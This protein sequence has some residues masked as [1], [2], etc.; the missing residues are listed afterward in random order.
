[1]TSAGPE[2]QAVSQPAQRKAVVVL[3][4]HRSGTSALTR[5]ISALGCDL[6]RTLMPPDAEVNAPGYWESV[7]VM[8]L[9]DRVLQAAHSVWHDWTAVEP[10]WWHSEAAAELQH[11]AR[12][13][14]E[15]E[16]GASRLFVLKDPR[17][18]RLFPFWHAVLSSAGVEPLVLL[19][20][21]NPLE[22]AASLQ[23]RNGFPLP[24]SHLLWQRHVLDA[25]AS[26]R[27]R[28]RLFTSYERLLHDWTGITQQVRATFDVPWPKSATE[29]EQE[30]D[31][32][33]SEQH[34]HH[35]LDPKGVL[36]DPALTEG[37]RQTYRIVS[38]W[39]EEGERAEDFAELDRLRAELD[40]AAPA[41]ASLLREG[42]ASRRREAELERQDKEKQAALVSMKEQLAQLQKQLEA[43]QL[44]SKSQ[45]VHLAELKEERDA[46]QL[47]TQFQWDELADAGQERDAALEQATRLEARVARLLEEEVMLTRLLLDAEEKAEALRQQARLRRAEEAKEGRAPHPALLEKAKE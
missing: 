5:V 7:P 39:A 35:S 47:Q 18:C 25:E 41:F 13:V 26:T 21:R 37:L 31:G 44:Q 1:M 36:A 10:S 3:G 34:R 19:P 22:V 15:A 28:P 32:F 16:F 2:T 6:P 40:A 27:G 20:L 23:K 29:A 11:E 38:R 12:S 42:M 46:L 33:V 9:N 14:L 17:I 30:L 45:V 4:M 8:R 43:S 24:F